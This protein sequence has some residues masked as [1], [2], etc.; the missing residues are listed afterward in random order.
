MPT[1]TIQKMAGQE[2]LEPPT[3]G[4]GDRCSTIGATD[5]N[6]GAN[7]DS[8]E[9]PRFYQ[10]ESAESHLD[11]RKSCLDSRES[12]PKRIHAP[13]IANFLTSLLCESCV[14]SA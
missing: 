5:L 9:I 4:F 3:V 8:I 7:R 12:Q 1:S 13:K 10:Y 6:F 14:Y 11:S 2:G